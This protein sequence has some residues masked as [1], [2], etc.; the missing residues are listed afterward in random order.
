MD[1]ERGEGLIALVVVPTKVDTTVFER[2]RCSTARSVFDGEVE[3]T[4]DL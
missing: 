4:P 2:R 3:D 1:G